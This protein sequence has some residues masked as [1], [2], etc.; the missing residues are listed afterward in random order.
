MRIC[1]FLILK[2]FRPFPMPCM[3]TSHVP[4]AAVESGSE[5][6]SY[7]LIPVVQCMP[8]MRYITPK[9]VKNEQVS[10]LPQRKKLSRK[11]AAIRIQGKVREFLHRNRFK[12][13][14]INPIIKY[15]QP[16]IYL[17]ALIIREVVVVCITQT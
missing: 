1:N 12:D 10:C 9:S 8:M 4:P 11:E 14:E 7:S 3:Y 15:H 13:R 17:T 16:S 6:L 5:M 2:I